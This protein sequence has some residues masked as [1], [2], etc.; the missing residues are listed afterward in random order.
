MLEWDLALWPMLSATDGFSAGKVEGDSPSSSPL[1]VE[2]PSGASISTLPAESE[3]GG[4]GTSFVAERSCI[5]IFV[6][7]VGGNPTWLLPYL[8]LVS[9]LPFGANNRL[10]NLLSM[11]LT[12]GSPTLAAYSLALTVLNGHWIAQR[13]SALSYNNV[14]SAVKILSGLQQS[15]LHVKADDPLLASLVVLHANDNYWETLEDL[16]NYVQTWS[17]SAVASILW[18][19]IAYI[20]TVVDSFTGVVTTS[21]LNSNGQAVGSILLWLLPIVVGWLQISP[22]CDHERV[23]QAMERANKIAYVASPS[24]EPRLA[25]EVSAK[26]AIYLS[27]GTGDV[28][29][30]EH[31][32]APIYNYARFLP[33]TLAVE[34]VYYAFREASERSQS[35]EPVDSGLE[36]QKWEKGDRNMRIHPRNRTGSLS[37]VSDY[38]KMKAIEFE[39]NPKPRSRWGPGVVSRFLLAALIALS[40]TWGTT[41]AAVV[42]AFFT[43]TKGIGCRSGSYLMYGVISTLV[44][45]LLVASSLLAHYSTFTDS[46]KDRYMHTKATRLAAVISIILRRVGKVLSALNTVWIILACLFQFGSVF[47]RCWCNSSVFTW[48][49]HA[50]N[51]IDV[52]TSDVEALNAPWIGGVALAGGC[53]ILFMGFVNVL[54]NPALPD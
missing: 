8:A 39:M 53:A 9:Q 13:F 45:M 20:F 51:V 35:Y 12:V 18:V 43:P 23:H 46:F 52:T 38:V 10:D 14:R 41:G 2:V 25:S 1:P 21:T 7:V 15:P 26:R 49:K 32:S 54:I 47:D 29:R 42:V 33:W 28:H 48:G 16:L 17:I 40:L 31:C 24:G 36:W 5:G 27:K 44:W 3:E 19:V 6:V 22:K 50:Y 37:Q 34:S 30:D 11:L 4:G